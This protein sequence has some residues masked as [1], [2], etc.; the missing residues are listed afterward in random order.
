MYITNLLDLDSFLACEQVC[1]QW[2]ALANTPWCQ[3]QWDRV[4]EF[5]R[6]TEPLHEAAEMGAC[7]LAE[8]LIHN[9]SNVNGYRSTV[10]SDGVLQEAFKFQTQIIQITVLHT[11]A[12][13]G[14]LEIVKLLLEHGANTDAKCVVEP[15]KGPSM[16]PSD[17]AKFA[18]HMDV[19]D[20]LEEHRAQN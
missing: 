17:F 1:Q 9:G 7:H 12:F 16:T 11:A 2:K 8:H 20:L 13:E 14:K 5:G 6:Q 4:E 3:P 15:L 18:G 19:F 10:F